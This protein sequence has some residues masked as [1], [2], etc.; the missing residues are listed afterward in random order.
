[1]L[2]QPCTQMTYQ[3]GECGSY[4]QKLLSPLVEESTGAY[5]QGKSR[6]VIDLA[7]KAYIEVR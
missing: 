6:G 5:R 7:G 4:W 3:R 2:N 1:M